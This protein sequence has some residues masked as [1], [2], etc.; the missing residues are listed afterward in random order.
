MLLH[1]YYLTPIQVADSVKWIKGIELC[2]IIIPVLIKLSI[3]VSILRL[4]TVAQRAV[5]IA[6][7]TLMGVLSIT[8]IATLLVQSMQCLPL[9]GLWELSVPAKCMHQSTANWVLVA[10]GSKQKPFL[11]FI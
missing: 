5:S 11:A 10:Y 1:V 9:R 4:V 2:C 8:G 6:I 3:C 7:C